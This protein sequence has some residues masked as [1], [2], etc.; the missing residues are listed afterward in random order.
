MMDMED[1]PPGV[2]LMDMA[3]VLKVK[4]DKHRQLQKRK[5]RVCVRGN[6]QEYGI[7][8][9]DTFAPCTQLS[10]VRLVIILALNLAL[11]VYHMDVETA[12]LNSALEEDLYVRLPRG[13]EH[14]GRT[15]AKLLEAVYGLKQAG[16]EWFE[17]S[18]AFIMAYGVRM[19]RSDIE[20]C[21][22]YIRD[23]DITV[24]IL[25]YVDDY[26]VATNSRSWYDSFVI[27]FNSKYACK[28]LG[29]LDLVMGIGVRWGPG[30]AYLSQS[31]YISQMV[32][33]YGLKDAKP[34]SLPMSPGCSLAPSDGK[35][36]TIPFRGLLGQLQ[37]IARC[38]RPDI[39]A[40]VS[41]LS[42]FCA[43]YGPEHFVALKQDAALG[44]A[45]ICMYG[46]G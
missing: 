6:K 13:L 29:V 5:A 31:G 4:L 44:R 19:R 1:V 12:F 39:M 28:D 15:C 27:A 18:D 35:D 38:T 45:L 11:E 2:R 37:W 20:P 22:Y 14:Q 3:L 9:F 34:A 24:I 30:V 33:T 43:S 7:D 32:D 16:K 21:L 25:A 10:S 41:A 36:A 8:Y 42:R 46:W 40:F 17:T 23:S 26:I